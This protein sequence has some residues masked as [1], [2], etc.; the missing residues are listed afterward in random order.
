MTRCVVISRHNIILLIDTEGH[1]WKP[2]VKLIV[3]YLQS[4]LCRLLV[5]ISQDFVL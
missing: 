3:T 2:A 4:L 5:N 1:Q